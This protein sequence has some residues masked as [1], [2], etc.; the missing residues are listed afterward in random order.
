MEVRNG[1][2]V[3]DERHA[4]K[5]EVSLARGLCAGGL[6]EALPQLLASEVA[7]SQGCLADAGLKLRLA[8]LL[9][10][11]TH[12][13]VYVYINVYIYIYTHIERERERNRDRVTDIDRYR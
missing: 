5:V 9:L 8:V 10:S 3:L 11:S 7:S 12:T 2:G 4:A 13:Y 6:R 1:F